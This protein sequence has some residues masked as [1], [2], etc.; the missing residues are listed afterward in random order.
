MRKKKV[1]E[2][3]HDRLGSWNDRMTE[4]RMDRSIVLVRVLRFN[5]Q[6]VNCQ[7]TKHT[8]NLDKKKMYRNKHVF[9]W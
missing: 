3:C 1:K 4:K 8:S 2:D 9:E 7:F 5:L 6:P